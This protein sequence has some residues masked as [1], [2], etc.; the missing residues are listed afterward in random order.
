MIGTWRSSPCLPAVAVKQHGVRRTVQLAA[1]V[2]EAQ[3]ALRPCPGRRPAVRRP[4]VLH[5]RG[6]QRVKSMCLKMCRDDTC[7]KRRE[8][9]QALRTPPVP[10]AAFLRPPVC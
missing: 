9:W 10:A 7:N 4:V 5:S 3:P 2:R 1:E 8:P 6:L